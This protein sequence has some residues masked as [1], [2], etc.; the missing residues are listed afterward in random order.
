[1]SDLLVGIGRQRWNRRGVITSTA[2]L[3]LSIQDDCLINFPDILKLILGINST[4]NVSSM[5]AL[6]NMHIYKHIFIV[7]FFILLN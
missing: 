6:N 7:F 4:L 2:N 1:M 5:S 3:V